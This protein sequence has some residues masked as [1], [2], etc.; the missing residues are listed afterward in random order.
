M[1]I[2]Q[3]GVKQFNKEGKNLII[4]DTAGRHKEEKALIKEMQEL[5]KKLKPD[6]IILVIDGTLGQTA[7]SQA[8]AFAQATPIGSI[9]VTKL[10]GTAKG[11]G[12]ISAAAATRAPIKFIGTGEKI[13]DL[14][15]FDPTRFVS[16]ILGMG[17]LEALLEEVKRANVAIDED[18]TKAMMK[19]KMNYEDIMQMF[20]AMNSMGGFRKI[21]NMMPGGLSHQVDDNMLNMSK[22]TM[23][24][25]RTVISSMTK[26]EKLGDVKLNRSR[27]ERLAKG[28]GV[29][30]ETIR[31]LIAQKKNAEKMIK[32][33]TKPRRKGPGGDMGGLPFPFP[34]G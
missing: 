1:K 16:R 29:T 28:S 6:E 18:R 2:A 24:K 33:M 4:V 32:Q 34:L 15:E 20:E 12:A 17:D 31:E 8:T 13:A 21:L 27:I 30:V 23:E 11:G 26:A 7:F 14:E 19:G 10:D 22:T 9:I 25:Y 5:N 3:K